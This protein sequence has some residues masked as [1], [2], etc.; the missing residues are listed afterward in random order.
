MKNIPIIKPFFNKKEETSVCRVLRSGWVTQ[1]TKVA[2]FEKRFCEFIDAKYAIAVSSC[3]TA[4]HLA[5]IVNQIDRDDEVILPSLTFI[6]TANVVLYCGA[7]PVF[8]DID[9]RTFNID[10]DKIENS[11]SPNTKA[12]IVVH[13]MGLP[14]DMDRIY[15]IAEKH[16][17]KVIEDAACAIGSKYKGRFIGADST[18]A[19]FSFHPRKLLTMGEGGMITTNNKKYEKYIRL[20]RHQGMSVSDIK[21]HS[22]NKV[23]F[24]KYNIV[25]YNYRLTDL[26]A[27]IGIEQLN[28]L[29]E[30]IEKRIRLAQRY[31][32]KFKNKDYLITPFVPEYAYTNYQSYCV[33]IK[34]KKNKTRNGLMN[35]LMSKHISTRRG[36]M[37]I[38]REKPYIEISKNCNLK[39]SEYASDNS[40]ILPLYHQMK[41]EE[42]D[43]IIRSIEEYFE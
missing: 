16:K 2:E 34:S 4:L 9:W 40:I 6:A 15:K 26:Q 35:Y 33:Y 37:C 43:Y 18:L 36:I 42:Q 17:L 25:G 3:T 32:E 29:Q 22:S 11:I 39:N 8:V 7:K 24:E 13:Q 21:R 5:L 28:K 41:K 38:H 20:L 19:C 31:N 30:I 1:G 23:I 10:S 14:A 27:A 12:I